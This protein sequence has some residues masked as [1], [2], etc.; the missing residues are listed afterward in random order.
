MKLTIEEKDITAVQN[1]LED[2][3]GIGITQELAKTLIEDNH[4]LAA[5]LFSNE[6]QLDTTGT[7]KVL[8]AIIR[9]VIPEGLGLGQ[10]PEYRHPE[11]YK[12][13]FYEEFH[14]SALT[15]SDI[16]ISKTWMSHRR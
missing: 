16:A 2:A 11:D 14:K 9:H 3:A 1:K 10:W 13:K 15:M 12:K 7:E 4:E 5:E 8:K 6:S